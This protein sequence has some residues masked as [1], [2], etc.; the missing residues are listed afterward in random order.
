MQ[1]RSSACAGAR[2]PTSASAL[3][4]HREIVGA[5][6]AVAPVRHRA[7]AVLGDH[8]QRALREIA[9]VVGEIGVD[10]LD[11]RLVRIVA[12][13]AER[14][15]AQEEIAQL[16]DAVVGDRALPGLTTLPT[17]F[18]IFSPRLNRKPCTTIW[19]GS[20]RPADIRNAGQ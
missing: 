13:L 10:A 3:R 12:V 16:V 6:H 2:A 14:H 4:E 5:R 11:D 7:A 9:E 19:L 8:R 20:G 15:L 1:L 17:D 18:D